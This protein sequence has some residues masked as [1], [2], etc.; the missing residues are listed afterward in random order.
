MAKKISSKDIFEKEDIFKGIRDSAK[1]TIEQMKLLST[2]VNE[3]AK[4]LQK[5][6]GTKPKMDS[7]KAIQ[8]IVTTQKEANKLKKDAIQIDKLH[9]QAVQQERKAVQ[10][11]EKINQQKLKTQQ[12]AQRLSVQEIKEK[13]RLAKIQAKQTKSLQAETNAYKKLVIE[14]RNAKNESKR[15]GAEMLILERSGKRNTQAYKQL[16]QSYRTMSKSAKQ[17]D[18]DLKKLDATVGDNFR[19]VGN[20]KGAI[21]GLVSTLG[22]LGAGI[23]IGQIFRNVTGIMIDFD[24]S[25]ADL[26]AI[27][28]KTKDELA[29]LT[30]QAKLLGET[31]QFSA[32]EIVSMQIEL[33][34]LGFTTKQIEG[35]TEAV[36]NFAAATG[37]D[38][39]SAAQVAGSAMRMFGL[40]TWEMSRAVSV[41]GVATTKSALS[42]ADY[43]TALSTLGPVAKVF[44]FSIEDTTALLGQL[45]NAGFDASS[46]AT[47]TR[48]ILLNLADAGG[49]LAQKIGRPVKSLD[50]MADAFKEIQGQGINLAEALE[51]TDVK[52]V[53]AFATF[54]NGADTLVEFRDSITDVDAELEIMAK[55]RLDSV[56]G[57]MKLVS[58]A[59]E[60]F[61]LNVDES[62]KA[63]ESLKDMLS[64]LAKNLSTIMDVV[65]TLTRVFVIFQA[66]TKGQ[67]LVNKLMASSFMTTTKS[68]KGMSGVMAKVGGAFRSLGTAIKNNL[69]GIAIVLIADLIYKMKSLNDVANTTADNM[70]N[71]AEAQGEVALAMEQEKVEVEALFTALKNTNYESVERKNLMD[72]INGRYGTTLENLEN[73]VD[74]NEQ[75]ETALEGVNAQLMKRAE[76]ESAR[77]GFQIT[78]KDQVEMKTQLEKM[79]QI[80]EAKYWVGGNGDTGFFKAKSKVVGGT[81]LSNFFSSAM[82]SIFGGTDYQS[83][84]NEYNVLVDQYDQ[85]MA[86]AEQ[87]KQD[88]ID[89]MAGFG[90]TTTTTTTTKSPQQIACES[91]GG[92]WNDKTK[93][94]TPKTGPKGKVYDTNLKDI[95]EYNSKYFKL[96]QDRRKNDE[97]QRQLA[98]NDDFRGEI[99]NAVKRAEDLGE[100]EVE[101]QEKLFADELQRRKDFLREEAL[102]EMQNAKE[103]IYQ[104]WVLQT[105]ALEQEYKDKLAKI[106]AGATTARNK[107]KAEYKTKRQDLKSQ[108]ELENEDLK[109]SMKLKAETLKT[110][111]LEMDKTLQAQNGSFNDAI[112][113]ALEKFAENSNEAVEEAS[114]SAI[115]TAKATAD[116]IKENWKTLQEF[117]KLGADYFIEQSNRKIAQID[118]EIAKA[119]ESY[120]HFKVLAQNGN[121]DAKESLAE[122][123]KIIDE[124]NKERLK[125]EKIQQR[126]RLTEAVL[127]TYSANQEANVANPLAK[128][129]T[130]TALLLQFINSLPA[131]EKGIEDTG[132]NGNGVDGRG[133]FHAIL[134]PNERVVPKSLNEKIGNLTNEELTKIAVEYKNG[135]AIDT[136]SNS[137][138]SLDFAILVNGI[139]ELKEVVKNKP[140]TNIELGEI[141]SSIMEVV[142]TTKKGQSTTYN[143]FKIRK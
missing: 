39:A 23:G 113:D 142:K 122:Q 140:E 117:V 143:R 110:A 120:N 13:E 115:A 12:Q 33:A 123:Q 92:T 51:L 5:S 97:K 71:L 32:T 87:Y 34:K 99:M 53:S 88:Y 22:T 72:E 119:E 77:I 62:S 80:L 41:L 8:K 1:L 37:A 105:E 20:Y 68:M 65:L 56:S 35:S 69:G 15:L 136:T 114:E 26:A 4:K 43:E 126:I 100:A 66:V 95:S 44:G 102:L 45:K 103:T 63:S 78:Q 137:R 52:S 67:I 86:R 108:Q 128:T 96:Q 18:K 2:E 3:T 131:F 85:T 24:Q 133:G 31:T 11:L 76:L 141:T 138:S 98:V 129:I 40:E 50:Q 70:E 109:L 47:A 130:D 132:K 59:W 104:N 83:I 134:H 127:T 55:K 82:A 91:G 61:I 81:G 94:C 28:G 118:K 48:K 17:G 135:T 30:A 60:G 58:S 125:Q 79:Q 54:L 106:P 16:S 107:L 38:L 90:T 14:T 124:K 112:H 19:N 57:Q 73:E 9:S 75:L 27:S 116:A 84:A 42:F 6:L 25:Q 49:T 10:E 29:G 111:F 36:S 139:N 46:A 64:F 89:K 21:S 121:I 74:W 93:T 7:Q 101:V